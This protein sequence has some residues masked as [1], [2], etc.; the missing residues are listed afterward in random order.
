MKR[1]K[2]EK[3]LIAGSFDPITLG[4]MDIIE[5]AAGMFDTVYVL[6]CVNSEKRSMFTPDQRL[7]L[8][9]AACAGFS[10]IVVE[11]CDGLLADYAV[12]HGIPVIVKGARDAAD[13]DYE[14]MM[15]NINTRL[16]D[17]LETILLP[18]RSEL[19]HISA[20]FV[21]ELIKYKKPLAGAVPD[22]VAEIIYKSRY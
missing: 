11:R 5:R 8:I 3:A 7:A 10:N 16:G 9:G 15:Y 6:L 20:T 13:F 22:S 19:S 17:G 18:A 14:K 4:H 21:R 2:F 1:M 12:A